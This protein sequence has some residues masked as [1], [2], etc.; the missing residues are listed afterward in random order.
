MRIRVSFDLTNKQHEAIRLIG[1]DAKHLMLFG[2]SRSGKTFVLVRSVIIRALA[3]PESRHAILRYRF[4][5]VK[6]S[7]VHDTFPK[8]MRLCFPDINYKIDK[9]DWFVEFPNNAT[10]WFGGLDDKERTEKILGQEYATLYLNECSQ[11]PYSSRNLAITRLAQKTFVNDDKKLRLKFYYDCNPPSKAH[12]TYK[13]FI[14]KKDPDG[15]TSI[16]PDNYGSLQMNP[17]DNLANLSQDYLD[18]LDALPIRLRQRFSEG[19]FGDINENSLW[20]LETLEKWRITNTDKVPDYQ[21]V[22][23]GVDPSGVDDEYSDGDAIGIV[24]AALGT[25]GNAYLLEDLTIKDSPSVWGNVV[26]SAFDRH[27]ADCVVAEKNFGG[28]KVEH[29]IQTARPN[30]FYKSVTASR[31]KVVRAEPI[32]ALHEKGKIRF[33]GEYPELEEELLSFTT[34]GYI[35]VK[36]PNRADAL[37]WAMAELFPAMVRDREKKFMRELKP[38]LTFVT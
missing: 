37:I 19:S 24:V 32:S 16:E 2:G 25:D 30:T 20:Q 35:G 38:D 5:H 34:T 33:I 21:R 26:A 17:C 3:S 29:V 1:G 14:L 10:I 13:L 6:A 18:E 12:W 7:I 15:Q 4:N 31:G 23:I 27:K 8:V 28:A 36:S 22:V 11:I 9:T